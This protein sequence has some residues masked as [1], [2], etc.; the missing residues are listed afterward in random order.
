MTTESNV[1]DGLFDDEG[2]I[3]ATAKSEVLQTNSGKPNTLE[4]VMDKS[5]YTAM[6][7]KFHV[8]YIMLPNPQFVFFPTH[9]DEMIDNQPKCGM[10]NELIWRK[11]KKISLLECMLRAVQALL[12]LK[13]ADDLLFP[14]PCSL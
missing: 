9:G 14:L 1:T 11:M 5:E 6:T 4:L 10:S 2:D 7:R 13:H 3:T 8:V 12:Y